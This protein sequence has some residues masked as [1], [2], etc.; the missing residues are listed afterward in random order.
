MKILR[1]ILLPFSII[2]AFILKLRNL[3]FQKAWLTSTAFAHPVICVGNLSLG[4][5]GKSPAIEYLIR[6]LK[7]KYQIATLSRGYGRKTTGFMW[8]KNSNTAAEVG[9]EPLQF[10]NKFPDIEVAVDEQR[11]RGIQNILKK[12]HNDV[13]LLDDAFQHRKVKAGFNI[14][15]TVYNDLYINDFVLPAGNLREP[16]SG[17]KRADVV[18]VTKCPPQL[19]V[20]KRQQI[21]DK[22]KLQ[23]HQQVFF[24]YI[25]YQERVFSLDK[26]KKLK[27]LKDYTLVSG[28]A[29]P[30]PL[31][32]FLNTKNPPQKHL[33]YKD[34][35]HFTAAEIKHLQ[36]EELI[37]T[38]EKDFT[39][40]KLH[41]PAQKLYF[42]SIQMKIM[43]EAE[44]FENKIL[45]YL[46]SA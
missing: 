33:V 17:A 19:S 2:Y 7:N 6:L 27:E 23:K 30:K 39:R 16:K 18:I 42:I 22:L 38:T 15:L 21:K 1:K 13:I 24:A 29:N 10:K 46:R 41:L 3:A 44:A 20:E 34:H 12:Q 31:L 37:L 40:L 25:E 32:N 26:S 36:K 9:D 43:D 14:L 45:N 11:V 28:I 8:V 5:T 4:G 35:H